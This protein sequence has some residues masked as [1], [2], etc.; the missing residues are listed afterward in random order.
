MSNKKYSDSVWKEKL[1]GQIGEELKKSSRPIGCSWLALQLY[2]GQMHYPTLRPVT[3][4]QY[5]ANSYFQAS[6][7]PV[8]LKFSLHSPSVS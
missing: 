4:V 8:T 2:V 7:H 5:I 3:Q 1:W 6:F